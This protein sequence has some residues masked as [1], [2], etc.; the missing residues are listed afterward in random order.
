M[1]RS[2]RPFLVDLA[3]AAAD[4]SERSGR[5][6]W[7]IAESA[8][9]DPR[10]VTKVEAGG[11]G[12]D[13]Q[14]NDD[15][16]HAVHAAVTSERTG[17]YAD[18]Q[19]VPDVARAMAQGFVYQGQWSSFRKRRHGAPSV[20]IDPSHFVVFGQNHDQVGNRAD[21]A[22]LSSLVPPDRLPLLAAIVALAPGVPLLFMGEEYGETAP[23]TYFVDHGDPAL[24][25]AVRRGRANEH[26]ENAA[27]A[28]ADPAD[29][30]TF[31]RAVLD[32]GQRADGVHRLLWNR[33]RELLALRAAE[34]ALRRSAREGTTASAVGP[35]VVLSTTHEAT[36]IVAFFNV[37]GSPQEAELPVPGGWEE[38]LVEG[39]PSADG[40]LKLGPWQCRVFRQSGTAR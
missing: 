36:T 9:N 6:C 8:A 17:Y 15:F 31:A 25:D 19:G 33:Y 3:A 13:A 26:G 32:H 24:L 7:L 22:R 34:P 12:M 5:P 1:D 23:F 10:T 14:W 16:H 18:Y 4:A 11:L 2:A 35:V 20:A 40:A 37:S 38:L 27:A 29:P 39:S 21:G 30:A 28:A